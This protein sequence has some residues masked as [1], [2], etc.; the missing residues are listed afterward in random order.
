M[1]SATG[2]L[3]RRE[4]EADLFEAWFRGEEEWL[5]LLRRLRLRAQSS[6]DDKALFNKAVRVLAG[7]PGVDAYRVLERFYSEPMKGGG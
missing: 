4:I 3:V 6:A 1:E 2:Q 5:A 7:T